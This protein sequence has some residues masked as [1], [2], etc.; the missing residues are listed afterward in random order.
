MR[1]SAGAARRWLDS[2]QKVN[3][4]WRFFTLGKKRPANLDGVAGQLD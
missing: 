1:G 2:Q 3:R 4:L